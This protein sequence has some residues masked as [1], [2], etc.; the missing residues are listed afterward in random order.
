M[1][2]T[3][4][5]RLR[6]NRSGRVLLL[7]LAAG[8]AAVG[9]AAVYAYNTTG[10][11]D[12]Q[13]DPADVLMVFGSPADISGALTQMQRWRVE[14]GVAEF[15]RGRAAHMLFTGGAAA[16]R[17]VESEVMAS[18]A[19]ELGVP[20]GAIVTETH[21]KTTLENIRFSLPTLMSRNWTRVECISSADHLP[22]IAVLMQDAPVEWRLHAAPTPDRSQVTVAEAYAEEAV[23]TLVLRSF[24]NAAEPVIHGVA[25]CVHWIV[26]IPKYVLYRLKSR[27]ATA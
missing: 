10:K 4:V 9:C 13:S 26:F 1:P 3:V 24:G 12:L 11:G 20:A 7:A 2:K 16:N 18:Y 6:E 27:H 22:R 15:R 14:E 23:A 17:F 25:V 21:S 8:V 5:R 19:K